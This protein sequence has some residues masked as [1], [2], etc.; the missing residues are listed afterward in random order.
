M[1]LDLAQ[2]IVTRDE[3]SPSTTSVSGVPSSPSRVG[4]STLRRF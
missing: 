1:P 3:P 4:K 2:A